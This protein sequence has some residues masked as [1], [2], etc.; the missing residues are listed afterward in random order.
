V[1]VPVVQPEAVGAPN[2]HGRGIELEQVKEIL[3]DPRKR[4]I[5]LGGVS[6]VGKTHL[7]AELQ[8]QLSADIPLQLNVSITSKAQQ[9]AEVVQSLATQLAG[10]DSVQ[11][12]TLKQYFAEL[13]KRPIKNC[14]RLGLALI[15]DIA[16][17]KLSSAE[18][19]VNEV[20][21]IIAETDDAASTDAQAQALSEAAKDDLVL[22]FRELMQTIA[23][24]GQTG[25]LVIDGLENASTSVVE[26]TLAFVADLPRTW[27]IAL[28]VN[29]ERSD[30]P[31]IFAEVSELLVYSGGDTLPLRGLTRDGML[32]WMASSNPARRS[33]DDLEAALDVTQGRPFYLREWLDGT[34]LEEITLEMGRKIAPAYQAR[35]NKLSPA[36][37]AYL[38][39]LCVLPLGL[40]DQKPFFDAL[41]N[42]I[43][44]FNSVSVMNELKTSRFLENLHNDRLLPHDETRQQ[45]LSILGNDI[46]RTVA[47]EILNE[48]DALDLDVGTRDVELLRLRS[49]AG[50][51]DQV[52]EIGPS[53]AA[54]LI[55]YSPEAADQAF[56]LS[57][58]KN[59]DVMTGEKRSEILLNQARA[60]IGTGRYPAALEFIDRAEDGM[61]ARNLVL[62]SAQV[63]LKALMRL[64]QY[65][66]ALTVAEHVLSLLPKKE[67]VASIETLR[68]LNTIY[69][70]VG[71]SDNALST[72]KTLRKIYK[73][74]EI[75]ERV[76][77]RIW[78]NLA[79]TYATLQP[80]KAEK[81]AKKAL[82]FAKQSGQLRDVGNAY[83]ALGEARRHNNKLGKAVAAYDHAIKCALALGNVDSLLWSTLGKVDAE[84]LAGNAA[85]AQEGLDKLAPFFSE[86]GRRHPLE[87]LHWELS[88]IELG[89]LTEV[90]AEV[91]VESLLKSYSEMGISWPTDYYGALQSHGK[92]TPKP[93]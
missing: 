67:S 20:A 1:S 87:S 22:A 11:E 73:N 15:G 4:M 39:R 17:A 35:F 12:A 28:A 38:S 55:E 34:E 41:P 83:L 61:S 77:S 45:V 88:K 65:P 86:E 81:A 72:A 26:A 85:T 5:L 37:Q 80:K 52:T 59:L 79:R 31:P 27:S 64:N 32:E 58:E 36:S 76:K 47:E 57:M 14:Y 54:R 92:K 3:L 40:T 51:A 33:E 70:D 13:G 49:D 8:S 48:F 7:L 63:R 24:G 16:K 19:V 53:V 18:G 6:G 9:P 56:E 71:D 62:S 30:G 90:P 89:L 82:R 66:D 43:P 2:L 74:N 25:T 21:S 44:D 50:R 29:T 23:D 75:D 91:D 78:R 69:R 60:M 68:I 84:L 10:S 42:G 46:K 93:L